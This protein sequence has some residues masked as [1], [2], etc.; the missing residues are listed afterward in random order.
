[1]I[2]SIDHRAVARAVVNGRKREEGEAIETEA[3]ET[4]AIETEAI[5]TEAIKGPTGSKGRIRL[6]R[7]AEDG[8]LGRGN[9]LDRCH[10][11]CKFL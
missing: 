1:L 4:E 3:I 7:Q 5:E 2:I 11:A 9:D 10:G 8:K 6:G